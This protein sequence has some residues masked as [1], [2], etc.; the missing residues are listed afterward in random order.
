M[1]NFLAKL[2]G[3]K[4]QR[5]LKEVAPFKDA[6][7]AIYP[8]IKALTNDQLRAKTIEFKNRI[9]EAVLGKAEQKIRQCILYRQ[10]YFVF[11]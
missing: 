3:N 5:D 8:T 6:T 2:F 11:L 10:F 7:I 4:S 9:N 1:A